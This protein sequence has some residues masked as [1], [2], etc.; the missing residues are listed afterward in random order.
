MISVVIPLYNK[1][2]EVARAINSVLSQ[3]F[4][5][6]ELIIV[7]DGSTDT[8]LAIAKSFSDRRISVLNKQNGGV[9]SARNHGIKHAKNDLVALLDGDD[10]WARD[11]LITLYQLSK[12][13]PDAS[14]YGCQYVQVNSQ[15]EIMRLNRFPD[16]KE[17][18]FELYNHL[19]A[20]NSSSVL[21]RK[22][23]FEK[24]GYFDEKLTHGEDTD[25]WI[26]ISIKS[27]V[28]YTS[29]I[30]SFCFTGGDPLTKSGFRTRK[31][32]NNLLSKIDSYLNLG[33][34]HW[35]NLLFDRKIRGLERFYIIDPFNKQI[36]RMI[37][38][39]PADKLAQ[40]E[41]SV[42]QK[43][44]MCIVFKHLRYIF[45][46]KFRNIYESMRSLFS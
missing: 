3:T 28:C 38:S 35:D 45:H 41:G 20:I 9:S 27:K 40:I 43:G 23:V 12:K 37:K 10:W 44:L 13:Y 2:D 6:F 36:R 15:N 39:I 21:L 16:I 22:K 18:Y 11:F 14:I 42:L 8:S 24:Y 32:E 17:G 5:D 46:S 4:T 25:M 26:R 31:F 33:G 34:E 29:E 1:E 19:F 30:L 7:D